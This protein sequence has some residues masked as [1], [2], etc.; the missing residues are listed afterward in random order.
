MQMLR[1]LICC[2]PPFAGNSNF[3]YAAFNQ[4]IQESALSQS[5]WTRHFAKFEFGIILQFPS[6]KLKLSILLHVYF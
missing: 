4:I 1:T 3:P 5:L 6:I 2:F